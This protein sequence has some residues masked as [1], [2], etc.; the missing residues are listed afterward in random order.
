V[1]DPDQSVYGFTGAD[2][3]LL[4]ELAPYLGV[5]PVRLR[6]NYRSAGEIIRASEITLG[7]VRGYQAHDDT[8]QATI[9]FHECPEGFPEQVG[10]IA[11]DIIPAALAG[12]E[13]RHL[14]D[15]AIL[16]RTASLGTAVAE[17]LDQEGYDY[18]R[19]D[20]AAPYGRCELTSWIED[21][22][23]WCAGGWRS[24]RPALAGLIDRWTTFCRMP[25]RSAAA[26]VESARLTGFLWARRV[27]TKPAGEFVE[28]LHTAFH[29]T[30][31][32]DEPSLAD[33]LEQAERMAAALAP[34]GE[35]ADLDLAALGTRH[36]SPSRLNLLTLHS[37]KGTE[38]EVV[39]MPGLDRGSFPWNDEKAAQARESR[40]LFYVG[41]TRARDE[42]HL[43]YSG[44][45]RTK[46]GRRWELGPSPFIAELMERLETES[47]DSA[48]E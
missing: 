27:P 32:R 25:R 45:V 29:G 10:R 11:R 6:L 9:G 38:Y 7:E 16:Y 22:A 21:C 46:S 47:D 44:W 8:R 23:A 24:A 36:G 5:E 37:A 30:L 1:G 39:I 4:N 42:V 14:G 12:R 34:S 48:G 26:R 19:I 33:Q 43:L 20:N 13:G 17:A 31:L 40:R 28:E 18:V 41:L 3:A 2:G 15:I 35:M